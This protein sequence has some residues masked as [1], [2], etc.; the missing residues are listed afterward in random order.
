MAAIEA[1]A[2]IR[3]GRLRLLICRGQ[4]RVIPMVQVAVAVVLLALLSSLFC[5]F[6]S[7][8]FRFRWLYAF[9]RC[10]VSARALSRAGAARP[11]RARERGQAPSLESL[12]P[13][14]K[15]LGTCL[16]WSRRRERRLP[17]LIAAI[18]SAPSR[19]DI[20]GTMGLP[21]DLFL[22]P[23]DPNLHW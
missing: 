18:F 2:P 11:R 16:R 20:T 7:F 1:S 13:R 21:V 22:S 6:C 15:E 8:R 3:I 5:F 14:G 10:V 17:D 9:V 12:E 19:V 23:P 4:P